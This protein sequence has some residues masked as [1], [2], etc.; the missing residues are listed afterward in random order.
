MASNQNQDLVC[1][2]STINPSWL[3][4]S[5]LTLLLLLLSLFHSFLLNCKSLSLSLS[6]SLSNQIPNLISLISLLLLPFQFLL[7]KSIKERKNQ[8]L[9]FILWDFA[10]SSAAI[11]R[12]QDQERISPILQALDV[13]WIHHSEVSIHFKRDYTVSFTLNG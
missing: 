6:L 5:S 10:I 1:N 4:S 13:L 12:T 2:P 9:N 11:R 8:Y 3:P 7:A